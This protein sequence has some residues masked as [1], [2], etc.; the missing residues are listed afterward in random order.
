LLHATAA[1]AAAVDA[2]AAPAAA[3]LPVL[4][5]RWMLLRCCMCIKLAVLWS[6]HHPGYMLRL[7][8]TELSAAAVVALAGVGAAEPATTPW[9]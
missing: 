9:E 8:G 3:S 6:I 2:A 5:M 7:P 1:R 4:L